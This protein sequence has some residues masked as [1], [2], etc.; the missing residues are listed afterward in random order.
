MA[1]R[2]FPRYFV[3]RG[4]AAEPARAV[5]PVSSIH[6]LD[7]F[8]VGGRHVS[9]REYVVT[10]DQS[11]DLNLL[12]GEN[13]SEF[14]GELQSELS[15]S[16]M[17]GSGGR[18]LDAIEFYIFNVQLLEQPG[19]A[20]GLNDPVYLYGTLYGPF[21]SETTLQPAGL[22]GQLT[23]TRGD[24]LEGLIQSAKH[25]FGYSPDAGV[26]G[27][28][29][30][31][32][33]AGDR[34]E[35]IARGAGIVM[36]YP[37]LPGDMVQTNPANELVVTQMLYD[38]LSALR[39]DMIAEKVSSPLCKMTL[40]VPNRML[41][42]E[43]L[44]QR[45]YTIEGNTAVIKTTVTQGF[46]GFLASAFGSIMKDRLDLPPEGTL[47]EFLEIAERALKAFRGWPPKRIWALQQR[48]VP[49]T[50]DIRMR[51]ARHT[52][53]AE[54]PRVVKTPA[55]P[56]PVQQAHNHSVSKPRNAAGP[57]ATWMKDFVDAHQKPGA[58]EPRITSYAEQA[59]A[60]AKL[61]AN[62]P[63]RKS[64]EQS[65]PSKKKAEWMNDFEAPV[66][67]KKDTG[68]KK[69][70]EKESSAPQSKPDWMKDFE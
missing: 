54:P 53:P 45:G 50:A 32:T 64:T 68:A 37:M 15:Y 4:D 67:T 69:E 30:H 47:N 31:I 10:V 1:V 59:K 29:L 38:V 3:A 42:E 58:P 22:D 63:V 28:S 2:P 21:P 44:K 40:P 34:E 33:L 52:A 35:E 13:K 17:I 26:S 5:D 19:N 62:N 49:A 24:L 48:I 66:T 27:R 36:A 14:P 56:P 7:S 9:E 12:P 20:P 18:L 60:A 8:F 16:D 65:A 23:V 61:A 25:P 11:G 43:Q 41:V 39:A 70:R 51:A 55:A 6:A 57:M 46:Q